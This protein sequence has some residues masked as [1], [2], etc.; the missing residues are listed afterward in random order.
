MQNGT[1]AGAI[2]EKEAKEKNQ[3]LMV[4]EAASQVTGTPPRK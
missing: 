1:V 3:D 2:R 4:L